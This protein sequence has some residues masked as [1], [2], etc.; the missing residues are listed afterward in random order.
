MM[1]ASV[2][3]SNNGYNVTFIVPAN[4][5]FLDKFANTTIIPFVMPGM[6]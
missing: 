6:S 2:H 4:Y 5:S 3:L 1:K